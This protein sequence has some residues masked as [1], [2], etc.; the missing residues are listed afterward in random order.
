MLATPDQRHDN[1][2]IYAQ[3]MFNDYGDTMV[4]YVTVSQKVAM[5]K[6]HN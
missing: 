4:L 5:D 6:N 2:Y 1:F 3:T